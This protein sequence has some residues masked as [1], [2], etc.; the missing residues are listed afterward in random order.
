M[1]SIKDLFVGAWGF[2]KSRSRA[3]VVFPTLERKTDTFFLSDMS[4]AAKNK[5]AH[6]R[7]TVTDSAF[8]LNSSRWPKVGLT[9]IFVANCNG[10]VMFKD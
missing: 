5:L 2:S 6:S 3:Y 1:I 8:R 4:F 10:I 7:Y 9:G